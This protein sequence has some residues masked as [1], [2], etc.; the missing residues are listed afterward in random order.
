MIEKFEKEIQDHKVRIAVIEESEVNRLKEEQNIKEELYENHGK[1]KN[2]FQ[3]PNLMTRQ[4][5]NSRRHKAVPDFEAEDL[6]MK[7][8]EK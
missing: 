2:Y 1:R 5:S 7:E 6:A 3:V 4:R 8:N